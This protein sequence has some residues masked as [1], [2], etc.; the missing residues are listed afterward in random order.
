MATSRFPVVKLKKEDIAPLLDGGMK[1]FNRLAIQFLRKGDKF[2]L[3][4]QMIDERRKK[5]DNSPVIFIDEVEGSTDTYETD[6]DVM[7][8][9]HELTKNDL[10]KLSD[11]GKNDIILIPKRIQVNPDGVTY[12]ANGNPITPCP[13]AIPPSP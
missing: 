9:Q 12:D 11:H 8:L 1:G 2:T 4:A 6:S 5:I 13:P 7:F 3:V 10:I